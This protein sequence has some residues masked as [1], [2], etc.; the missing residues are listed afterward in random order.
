MGGGGDSSGKVRLVVVGAEKLG[1]TGGV[2]ETRA[3]MSFGERLG[4]G[5]V[6]D[7][8]AAE[9]AQPAERAHQTILL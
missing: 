6:A 5:D 7:A 9:G 2:Y 4:D 3:R 1:L 8:G